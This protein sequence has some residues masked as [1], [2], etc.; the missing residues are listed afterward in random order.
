MGWRW[1]F[2]LPKLAAYLIANGAALNGLHAVT[3]G[4]SVFPQSIFDQLTGC[5]SRKRPMPNPLDYATPSEKRRLAEIDA[6]L[7]AL[8][9]LRAERRKIMDRLHKRKKAS[10]G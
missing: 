3:R 2:T 6:A 7:T 4:G 1:T 8:S 10:E 5:P 9:P